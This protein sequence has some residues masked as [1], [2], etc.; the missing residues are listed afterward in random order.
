[1]EKFTSEYV[2]DNIVVSL[3]ELTS[4]IT[5]DDETLTVSNKGY[6]HTMSQVL[7]ILPVFVIIGACVCI[8]VFILSVAVYYKKKNKVN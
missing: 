5:F 6:T 3:S 8:V 2:Y 7:D 4:K 1:M